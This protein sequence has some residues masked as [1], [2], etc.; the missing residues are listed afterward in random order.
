MNR[1]MRR[2]LEA[3]AGPEVRKFLQDAKDVISS[4]ELTLATNMATPE[5]EKPVRDA[6]VKLRT[7]Y[8]KS[9][10]VDIQ[11]ALLDMNTALD[12]YGKVAQLNVRIHSPMTS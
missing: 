2:R 6:L 8:E 12:A 10:V 9:Q 3:M 7:A 11:A 1:K 4:T 5:Q